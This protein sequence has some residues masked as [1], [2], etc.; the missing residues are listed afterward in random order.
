MLSLVYFLFTVAIKPC[1][2]VT[3]SNGKLNRAD[4]SRQIFN[5]DGSSLERGRIVKA[6]AFIHGLWRNNPAQ[7]SFDTSQLAVGNLISYTYYKKSK[8]NKATPGRFK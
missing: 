1:S 3:G 4:F 7:Y 2:L 6:S 5:E 8:N